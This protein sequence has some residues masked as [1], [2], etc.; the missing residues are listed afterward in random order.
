MDD[1]ATPPTTSSPPAEPTTIKPGW[2]TTEFW[3]ALAATALSALY[4]SGAMTNST[5]L[6]IAGIAATVLTALGYKVTRALVK[7]A[8]ALLLVLGLAGSVALAPGC[9]S[10]QPRARA[11]N[12]LEAGL[13]CSAAEIGELG[14][15][16]LATA[17]E[18]ALKHVAGDGRSILTAQ[19]K[20]GAAALIGK[21]KES[22]ALVAALELLATPAR[23]PEPQGLLATAPGPTP[24]EWG[25]VLAEVRA[26]LGVRPA[27]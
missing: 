23:A 2:K 7:T 25:V 13:S 6:A 4:A 18:W 17:R 22:C 15:D 26:E 3:L 1:T 8:G 19:L 16:A 27:P 10:V 11:A 12:G 14:K 24:E 20:R 9:A 21:V 5:A